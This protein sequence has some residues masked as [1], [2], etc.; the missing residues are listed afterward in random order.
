MLTCQ[1]FAYLALKADYLINGA[2]VLPKARLVL[3]QQVLPFH[4]PL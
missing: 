4:E 3:L 2:P 1:S